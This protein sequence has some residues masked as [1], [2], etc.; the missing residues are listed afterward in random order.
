[1]AIAMRTAATHQGSIN[2]SES[3]LTSF[4]GHSAARPSQAAMV[5][6]THHPAALEQGND[7]WSKARERCESKHDEEAATDVADDLL[8]EVL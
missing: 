7:L 4:T 3:S 2:H 5:M 8:G 1:M 6:E